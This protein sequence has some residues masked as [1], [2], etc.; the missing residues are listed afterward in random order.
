MEDGGGRGCAPVRVRG[1]VACFT[2]RGWGLGTDG[3]AIANAS[4]SATLQSLSTVPLMCAH[5]AHNGDGP[6]GVGRGATSKHTQG[7]RAAASPQA[8]IDPAAA[9][10]LPMS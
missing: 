8:T 9:G 7:A 3:V 1:F 4:A 10:L 6:P 2:V 5:C